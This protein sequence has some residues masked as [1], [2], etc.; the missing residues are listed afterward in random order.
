MSSFKGS[1]CHHRQI[2]F[3][4]IM[5]YFSHFT[6][7]QLIGIH[8]FEL[9]YYLKQRLFLSWSRKKN[10]RIAYPFTYIFSFSIE[11]HAGIV[12]KIKCYDNF[13]VI[14]F[15]FFGARCEL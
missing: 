5:L 10:M 9:K 1:L 2:F 7:L 8:L 3:S 15:F 4:L 14:D 12:K 13:G 11:L 6:Y